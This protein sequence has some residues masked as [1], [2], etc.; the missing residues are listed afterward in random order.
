[1]D[2]AKVGPGQ[3]VPLRLRIY[4]KFRKG[5]LAGLSPEIYRSLDLWRPKEVWLRRRLRRLWHHGSG[6]VHVVATNLMFGAV[7]TKLSVRTRGV[8]LKVASLTIAGMSHH[9]GCASAC[10]SYILCET[11]CGCA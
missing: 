4:L 1:M 8:M 9:S 11:W 7:P 3:G 2:Q 10:T 6:T 5:E